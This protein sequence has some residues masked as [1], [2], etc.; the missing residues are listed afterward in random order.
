MP[1][2]T[3]DLV[4]AGNTAGP[5]DTLRQKLNDMSQSQSEFI[6]IFANV[7]I[8]IISH[9]PV[10]SIDSWYGPFP[11]W[12]IIVTHITEHLVALL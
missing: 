3:W 12:F 8:T 1:E 10:I 9:P 6:L 7:G 4:L 5:W 2:A 11:G